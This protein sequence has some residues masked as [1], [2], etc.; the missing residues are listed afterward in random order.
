MRK[1]YLD[2]IRWATVLLVLVYHVFYMF[3]AAGVPASIG[4][5]KPVQYQDALLYLVYPWFMVLLFVVS[6]VSSRYALSKRG[7]K[8]FISARTRKLLVP[9]TLGLLVFQWITGYFNVKI[10]GG[11]DYIPAFARYPIFALSGTGPLWFI[12][13][14]WL[15]SLLLVLIRK[16]DK[17]DKLWALGGRCTWPVLISFALLIWG[18]SQILNPP[19]I[20][21]YRFGIY[22]VAFLLGYFVFSH[23]EVQERVER[24]HLPMLIAAAALGVAYTVYYF[25]TDYSSSACLKSIFTNVYA[26]AAVLAILGCAKA[27]FDKTS[28]FASYMAR[29]SFGIY[30]VHYLLV[31]APCWWLKTCTAL[32][33]A[34]IYILALLI[35]LLGSPA[36]YELLRR[37]PF[38]RYTVLGIKKAPAA[39]AEK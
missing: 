24:M 13:I 27:W 25:G 18:G 29:S 14:L 7:D 15:F 28:P 32:P 11:L 36:L 31:L 22:F 4:P 10:G 19:V 12:Q 34:L 30:I 39:K 35:V 17:N 38:L 1:H 16:L 9:S 5:F 20:T 8:E 33:P 3:N 37:I 6:G 2:N 21:T 23:D 26:W